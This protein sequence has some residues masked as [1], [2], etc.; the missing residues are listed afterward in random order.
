[1]LRSSLGALVIC[2]AAGLAAPAIADIR[3]YAFYGVITDGEDISGYF[4]APMADL[5]GDR[6]AEVFTFDTSIG[7]LGAIMG[8]TDVLAGGSNATPPTPS[9]S[10]GA[11]ITINGKTATIGGAAAGLLATN[12]GVSFTAAADQDNVDFADAFVFTPD[13]P[14][15][16]S[17]PFVP[18]GFGAGGFNLDG[19]DENGVFENA[20]ANFAIPEPA[21]W[22]MMIMGL[23]GMGAML[24][25]RRRAIA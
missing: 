8:A 18:H 24:R 15:L 22:A 13:A 3:T 10:M 5:T 2:A 1:M 17:T 25:R 4:T 20:N 7:D 16:L 12:A 23:G 21:T 11:T 19:L 9:P 14:T 6:I